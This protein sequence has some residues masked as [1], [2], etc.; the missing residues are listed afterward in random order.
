MAGESEAE[1]LACA[2]RESASIKEKRALEEA[3]AYCKLP[4]AG[5][6]ASHVASMR[7]RSERSREAFRGEHMKKR[8]EGEASPF[9]K[10]CIGAPAREKAGDRKTKAREKG[11]E[12]ARRAR[13]ARANRGRSDERRGSEKK[14]RGGHEK[15]RRRKE[16][17][18]GEEASASREKPIK[19]KK[20]ELLELFAHVG[21][22]FYMS[23]KVGA[24]SVRAKEKPSVAFVNQNR[25]GRSL[26]E[27]EGVNG[28]RMHALELFEGGEAP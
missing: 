27:R 20:L 13:R 2:R 1:L 10:L 25:I 16:E 15:K 6:L 18:K 9:R 19:K 3:F 21:S 7:R 24:C 8:G 14:R 5:E 26:L 17:E 12:L 28:P 22:A 4:K 11:R 23:A